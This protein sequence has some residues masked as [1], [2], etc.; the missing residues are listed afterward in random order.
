V[1]RNRVCCQKEGKKK[2]E[3]KIIK[4]KREKMV[5]NTMILRKM[6]VSQ[7]GFCKFLPAFLLLIT[8]YC[9][10]PFIF[11]GLIVF[12]FFNR[13]DRYYLYK[14]FGSFL[15]KSPDSQ[16]EGLALKTLTHIFLV[17]YPVGFSFGFYVCLSYF[18]LYHQQPH[19]VPYLIDVAILSLLNLFVGMFL[20]L[21]AIISGLVGNHHLHQSHKNMLLTEL[22]R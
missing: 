1:N 14:L 11:Y 13:K 18:I 21:T 9:L 4:G 16:P 6:L 10:V 20:F 5:F 7:A 8:L 19:P 3:K 15:G 2:K 17:C 22:E 12:L